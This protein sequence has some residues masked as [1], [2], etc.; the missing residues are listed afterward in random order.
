MAT[1]PQLINSNAVF[2]FDGYVVK[3]GDDPGSLTSVGACDGDVSAALAY[4]INEIQNSGGQ[5]I[6]KQLKDFLITCDFTLMEFNVDRIVEM[7][8]GLFN[9]AD[10]AGTPVAGGNQVVSSGNWSYDQLIELTGQNASG[11]QPTINSVTGS[12]DG[13]LVLDTDYFVVKTKA[14]K[15][16]IYVIDSVTVTTE[17]QDI[18][19]NSDY[20]PAAAKKM[21]AG[22]ATLELT[23]K[24]VRFENV[25]DS[26]Q[27]RYLDVYSADLGDAGFTFSFG[28]ALNEGV[29][30]TPVQLVGRIDTNRTNGD[31]LLQYVDEQ[32]V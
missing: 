4:T 2:P 27:T 21:T 16:A 5:K 15:W 23:P 9:Q 24:Y 28:S 6:T 10:I 26:G 25:N 22:T 11:A 13:A 7:T 19:V 31:Q 14:G 3:V 18:T 32:Q 20:T 8:G 29:N 17:V 12:V 30:T 1:Q